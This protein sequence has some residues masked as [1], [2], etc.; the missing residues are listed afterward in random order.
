[1]S[2]CALAVSASASSG[3]SVDSALASRP[4]IRRSARSSLGAG[5]SAGR[6]RGGPHRDGGGS[7]VSIRS[8][9]CSTPASWS[10]ICHASAGAWRSA[11]CQALTTAGSPGARAPSSDSCSTQ[12]SGARDMASLRRACSPISATTSGTETVRRLPSGDVHDVGRLPAALPRL[13]QRGEQGLG[14]DPVL[15]DR[16]IPRGERGRQRLGHPGVGECAVPQQVGEPRV[17]RHVEHA[18]RRCRRRA[19]PPV[20]SEGCPQPASRVWPC[21]PPTGS[22]RP[23][24]CWA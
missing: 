15:V 23:P 20:D 11:R 22:P 3:N 2:S 5:L 14:G 7:R 9:V 10:T 17:V 1:M 19:A 8:E 13:L 6:E 4:R 12:A 24:R 18:A 21:H 16:G